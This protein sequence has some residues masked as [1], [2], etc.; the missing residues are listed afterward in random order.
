LIFSYFS[1]SWRRSAWLRGLRCTFA[2]TAKT[3]ITRRRA[4]SRHW[5]SPCARQQARGDGK[6][7]ILAALGANPSV[8][9]VVAVDEDIDIDD[10]AELEVGDRLIVQTSAGSFTY[11]ISDIRIVDKDDRTVIVPTD[12]A[13]LTLSTCYPFNYVGSAPDRYIISADAVL[14]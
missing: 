13:V 11:E 3:I 14:P 7:A 4:Y 9:H 10:P 5:A 6:N 12:H 1:P 2:F 8:K